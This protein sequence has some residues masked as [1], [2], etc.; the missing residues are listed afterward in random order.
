MSSIFE[1]KGAA[2]DLYLIFNN[3]LESYMDSEGKK[4]EPLTMQQVGEIYAVTVL[5]DISQKMWLSKMQE[6]NEPQRDAKRAFQEVT[7]VALYT[8][9]HKLNPDLNTLPV[10]ENR[11]KE[12]QTRSRELLA[13]EVKRSNTIEYTIHTLLTRSEPFVK[14][15]EAAIEGAQSYFEEKPGVSM[16][17]EKIKG[18]H[19]VKYKLFLEYQRIHRELERRL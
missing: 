5:K 13:V 3:F 9:L 8:T 16:D 18:V 17:E 14:I 7:R 11:L 12:Y 19:P 6:I 4:H 10:R 15:G 1:S 2:T